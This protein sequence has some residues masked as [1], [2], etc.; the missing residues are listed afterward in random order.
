M[1][2]SKFIEAGRLLLAFWNMFIHRKLD[3]EDGFD[4]QDIPTFAPQVVV[5]GPVDKGSCPCP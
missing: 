4:E 2:P 5:P 3:D 1:S